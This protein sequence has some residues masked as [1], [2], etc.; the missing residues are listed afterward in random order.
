MDE[1]TTRPAPEAAGAA[2]APPRRRW[3][4]RVAAVA[5]VL[6]VAAALGAWAFL[7][8]EAGVALVVREIVQRSGGHLE[9]DG[10][11]GS[12]LHTIRARRIAWRCPAAQATATDVVL[13]W[14]PLALFSRGLVVE[15]LGAHRLELSV[16]ASGASDEPTPLPETLALPFDVTIDHLAVARLDWRVG[17][18][19]GVIRGLALRYSGGSEAHRIAN[20][21][22]G[23][24]VWTLTGGAEIA[25]AKPFAIGGEL[26]V[27]GQA[28]AGAAEATASLS[29][30]LAALK[31]DGRGQAGDAH[32]TVRAALAPLAPVPLVEVDADAADVDLAAWNTALPSTRLAL[33]ARAEPAADGTT[34]RV[35][36]SNALAGAIDAGRVPLDD[37]SANFTWRDGELA[38]DEL[39][40]TLPGG[41]RAR[42]RA[43]IP[44][45]DSDT[46]GT[47]SLELADV[48]LRRIYAPLASTRLSGSIDA[49][50]A[51]DRQRIRGDV[52]DRQ[53]AG[54]I[55]LRFDAT[56]ADGTVDL[57]AF[58]LAAS[59]G[60]LAGRGR[61][62]LEGE[63]GFELEATA[64]RFDPARYGAFP[65]GALDGDIAVQ[66]A[67]GARWHADLRLALA[68]ASNLAGVA[69]S[70][71][72]AGS[73]AADR[74][75][76]I[77]VD[78][79]AG[80][81]RVSA[82]GAVGAASDVLDLRL[83]AP[84]LSEIT[85]LLPAAVPRTLAGALHAKARLHG[86]LPGG[87]IEVDAHGKGLKL[88]RAYTIADVNA[89]FALAEAAARKDGADFAGRNIDIELRASDVVAPQGRFGAANGTV[90]GTLA[91]HRIAL[92]FTSADIGIEATAQGALTLPAAGTGASWSGSVDTLRGSGPYA[93]SLQAPAV[94]TYA[95]GHLTVGATRLAVADGEMTISEFSWDEGRIATRG[96]YAR[97]PLATLARIAG[98]DLPVESTLTLGG[99]WSLAAAPRL[100]GTATLRRESG[101]LRLRESGAGAAGIALGVGALEARA[102]FVDDAVDAT[103]SFE[104]SRGGS[105]NATLAIGAIAGA[106]GRIVGQ[107]PLTLRVSAELPTLAL[108]QPW[109]GSAAVVDGR[110]RAEITGSG[111]IEK[112]VLAGTLHGDALRVDAPQYGVHF[113]DGRLAAH[114]GE[115]KFVLDEFVLSAGDGEFRASGTATSALKA[116]ATT[117]ARIRWQASGFRIFNRPDL[118]LVVDG[119]GTL[120]ISDGK[121]A[122]TGTLKADEGEIVYVSDT[123]A[124]LGDDVV[125]KGWDRSSATEARATD[126]PL[127][128]DIALDF[129]R[130]LRFS[131]QGLETGLSGKVRVT[132][133]P[134]GLV[135]KGSIRAVNGTYHAFGQKLDI[136]RGRLIFDG[137]L[138]NPGLDIV[139]L[140]KNLSVEAGV[141]VT[142]T[143]RV[144]IIQLTSNP[145]VPDSEKLSWLVLGHGLDRTSGNDFAALQAA[146]ALLLGRE[147]KPVTATI[148][149]SVG[150]DDI[151]IKSNSSQR[152][153]GS[154]STGVEG[155]VVAFG[156]RLTDKLTLVYEQGLSVAD[157]ALKLEYS[158]TR[159]IKLRAETGIISG[160]GIQYQRSFD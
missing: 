117:T 21:T 154:G 136:D 129:G 73:F 33:T 9:V 148:A 22:L 4:R 116:D 35:E 152:G 50:L 145:P 64:R 96:S 14:T 16:D 47:W 29:G 27:R 81:A 146:S 61:V 122:L 59:G 66:G 76:D 95:R 32:F 92:A 87:A 91:A 150:L 41:A 88:G 40:A 3:L 43:R 7:A 78:L 94:V 37:A 125:V 89:R 160:V 106:P 8:S 93:L 142:G 34:G 84:Q 134:R 25:A 126:L 132:N 110:A 67:L 124:V 144:P 149:E 6:L 111:T 156:K 158:L 127:V 97:V 139:A 113:K 17:P 20:L 141:K 49:D 99:E 10:A 151:S 45:G 57:P 130:R 102:R 46:A 74:V 55:A 107:A 68:P 120:A 121:L 53:L 30:T 137:P 98:V 157:S 108:L 101:D 79:A 13:S 128:L 77:D 135:G 62:A 123:A 56:V 60:E 159:N 147:S 140:R 65:A 15:A 109:I 133:G 23:Q 54:G 138:D 70:G 83:D 82:R 104:S 69:V 63:R 42:G 115:G 58:R 52:T 26:T 28:P 51:R 114:A 72:A 85:G 80:S 38:L 39:V 103:G 112:V 48:D 119:D 31:V 90:S 19:S 24:N 75:H 5:T 118:H 155:N 153:G 12:L 100:N 105:A 18:N 71:R 86:R 1:A 131:S 36:L 11:T 44:L 143:V 2:T